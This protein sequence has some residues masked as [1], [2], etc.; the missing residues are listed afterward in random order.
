MLFDLILWRRLIGN[1]LMFGR[2]RRLAAF[3]PLNQSPPEV[4][5]HGLRQAR[6]LAERGTP[7]HNERHAHL[8][9]NGQLVLD[10]VRRVAVA[11]VH[12]D[13]VHVSKLDEVQEVA[14]QRGA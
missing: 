14:E 12:F 1:R 3:A 10:K 8:S 11:H 13:T 7:L 6:T 2:R 9:A 4:S 5:D